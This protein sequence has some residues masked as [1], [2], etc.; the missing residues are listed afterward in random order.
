M[1]RIFFGAVILLLALA[2]LLGGG[3]CMK[4]ATPNSSDGFWIFLIFFVPGGLLFWLAMGL[5]GSK[6]GQSSS[7]DDHQ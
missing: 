7:S 4:S 1:I 5:W 6:P 2:F 3:I